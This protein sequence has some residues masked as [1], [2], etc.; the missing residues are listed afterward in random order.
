MLQLLVF[1]IWNLPREVS[2]A[3]FC[4]SYE[5]VL[6]LQREQIISPAFVFSEANAVL[7]TPLIRG[8]RVY[9]YLWRL[10]YSLHWF[11]LLSEAN[12]CMSLQ[13][14]QE[15]RKCFFEN[16]DFECFSR[17]TRG[18]K[19]LICTSSNIYHVNQRVNRSRFRID[20]SSLLNRNVKSNLSFRTTRIINIV[21]FAA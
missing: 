19:E 17:S 15:D 16:I 2:C 4:K 18:S 13:K 3:K 10:C 6:H 5:S 1:K 12:R 21:I 8:H 9:I 11:M 20:H 14:S 7:N